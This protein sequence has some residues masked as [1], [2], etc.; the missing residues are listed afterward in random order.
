[1]SRSVR[2]TARAWPAAVAGAA[3]AVLLAGCGGGD[4]AAESSS[5]TSGTEAEAAGS[6]PAGTTAAAD[7]TDFCDQAAGIDDRVDSALSDAEGDD[8]S[9]ADAFRQIATELRAIEAPAAITVDWQAMAGGLDR[10]AEAF[11]GLDITDSASLAALDAAQ[12]DLSSASG[13]V[14]DY[15]HDQCG[16][17]P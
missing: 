7:A 4:S 9:V 14:E 16:I 2:R 11:A 6:D 17:D 5:A 12:G 13:N 10:M 1:M 15:L 8:P 3:A